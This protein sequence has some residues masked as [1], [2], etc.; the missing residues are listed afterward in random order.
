MV[1]HYHITVTFMHCSMKL[2]SWQWLLFVGFIILTYFLIF[3][4]CV[5]QPIWFT[6]LFCRLCRPPWNT[7]AGEESLYSSFLISFVDLPVNPV[8]FKKSVI[9]PI[10]FPIILI[11]KKPKFWNLH[12]LVKQ[13]DNFTYNSLSVD[14]TAGSLCQIWEKTY[15][16]MSCS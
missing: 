9:V 8:Y 13:K 3:F 15:L 7:T 1:V 11:G 16:K 12:L 10:Y 5:N 6:M 2:A 14:T 4:I